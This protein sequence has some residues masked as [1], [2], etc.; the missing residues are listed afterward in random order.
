MNQPAAQIDQELEAERRRLEAAVAEA[1]ADTR[2]SVPHDQVRAKMLR[3]IK[4]L[5]R[6]I[7][8]P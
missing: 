6:K 3:E 5:N 2:P 7:A 1:R 8:G 4:R